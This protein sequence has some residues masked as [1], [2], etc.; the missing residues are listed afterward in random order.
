LSGINSSRYGEQ[1]RCVANGINGQIFTLTFKNTWTGAINADWGIAGNWSCG[2][3][4]DA[5][6][7]VIINFGNV[8]ISSNTTIR[9][10][11]IKPEATLTT[12]T[13]AVLTILH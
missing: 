9:S 5:Y 2:S 6:T 3:V 10:L 13:G 8:V 4:P 1:F 12:N 7:D 11:V